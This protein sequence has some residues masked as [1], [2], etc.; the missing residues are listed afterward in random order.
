[1]SRRRFQIVGAELIAGALHPF[2][3]LYLGS[4]SGWGQGCMGR[5]ESLSAQTLLAFG[6]YLNETL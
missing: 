3:A 1:M 6:S 2:V 4:T 5:S